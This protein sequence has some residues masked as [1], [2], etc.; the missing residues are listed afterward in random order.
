MKIEEELAVFIQSLK[1][2]DI[3]GEV[4]NKIKE[5]FLDFAGLCYK[6]AGVKTSEPLL[7]LLQDYEGVESSKI[8]TSTVVGRGL[9]VPPEYACLANGCFSHSL[10]LDDVVNEAS[11]HPGVVVF[12]TVLA[13]GEALESKGVDMITASVVGYETMIRLGM[14]AN[15]TAHYKRGFHPTG[16]CGTFAAAAVTAKLMGLNREE[17]ISALG[18]SASKT[19]SSLEFLEDGAW[20]KRLHPGWASH[21]GYM[22]SKLAGFGFKGPGRGI[23]GRYG[24]LNSYTDEPRWQDSVK[25]LG[26]KYFTLNTSIKPHACCRYNQSPIDAA[27]EVVKSNN[28]S[29]GEIKEIN[30][31]LVG[32]GM[33]LVGEPIEEKRN[34]ANIVDAQFSLP[35]AVSVAVIKG[36]AFLEEFSEEVINSPEIKD[37]MKKVN[38]KRDSELEKDFPRKWPCRVNLTTVEGN[39]YERELYY[40]RGDPQNPLS[41]EELLAKFNSLTKELER[42]KR[43]K[44]IKKIEAL[45]ELER[46]GEITALLA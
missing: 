24:F 29:A 37:M 32:P 21:S 39:N 6:G 9:K 1:Y 33:Q 14:A 45:E 25:E 7:K 35:F 43:D 18:I 3:P 42:E 20:T 16:T 44:L 8:K 13:A 5:L 22:A 23:G 12:P 41:K 19:A 28:I 2:E 38:C 10:E 46:I 31:D 36:K 17:I 26:K 11:L 40:P 15:P 27:L 4:V 34:P 30:I